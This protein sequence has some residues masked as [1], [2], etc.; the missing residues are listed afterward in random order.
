MSI[1]ELIESL[2]I[3]C[4]LTVVSHWWADIA[5]CV[6]WTPDVCQSRLGTRL[7]LYPLVY[8]VRCSSAVLGPD[9]LCERGFLSIIA[10]NL[11]QE[12]L[13]ARSFMDPATALEALDE[14]VVPPFP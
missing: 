10:L 7:G 3:S 4:D 12:R 11:W 6:P 1:D 14:V 5:M 2:D 8:L 13:V 9:A